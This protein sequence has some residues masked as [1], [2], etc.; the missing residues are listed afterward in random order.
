MYATS[1]HVQQVHHP[2]PGNHHNQA[3]GH[4]N[5]HA[6]QPNGNTP[7]SAPS[8]AAA[9]KDPIV[10]VGIPSVSIQNN[11]LQVGNSQSSQSLSSGLHPLIVAYIANGLAYSPHLAA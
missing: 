1:T 8:A 2:P 4:A 11:Q 10:V 5:G 7:R 3:N 6:H 9:A